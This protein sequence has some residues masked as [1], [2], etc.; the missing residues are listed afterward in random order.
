MSVD[1]NGFENVPREE[2]EVLSAE[3]FNEYVNLTAR[4]YSNSV[5]MYMLIEVIK[6]GKANLD[7]L[8][9]ENGVSTMEEIAKLIEE[10]MGFNIL[11]T[12]TR[13]LIK[14]VPE[15]LISVIGDLDAIIDNIKSYEDYEEVSRSLNLDKNEEIF[16]KKL[17]DIATEIS[18]C[19]LSQIPPEAY[20][21]ANFLRYINFQNTGARLDFEYIKQ[22]RANNY[23]IYIS[24]EN[25]KG[26][27]LISFDDYI[28]KSTE[29]ESSY[30]ITIRINPDNFD[31]SQYQTVI[32]SY[33]IPNKW[34]DDKLGLLL[35]NQ[36]IQDN[37]KWLMNYAFENLERTLYLAES[38]W[39]QLTPETQLEYKDYFKGFLDYV[40]KSGNEYLLSEE[41][42]HT[43]SRI[44]D[45]NSDDLMKIY[46]ND[47]GK[48]E[49]TF[50]YHA[51]PYF[52]NEY[53]EDFY[54]TNQDLPLEKKALVLSQTS[55][56]F[57]NNNFMEL[58]D[59][60]IKENE[61]R[62]SS[63]SN[64]NKL[65]QNYGT[66]E[67]DETNM[68]HFLEVI[69]NA[70]KNSKIE[71]SNA[72]SGIFSHLS[73]KNQIDYYKEFMQIGI[74][75]NASERDIAY[76][77]ERMDPN[78]KEENFN[79]ILEFAQSISPDVA[80]EIRGTGYINMVQA[81]PD[82]RKA[83]F[84]EKNAR[85][86]VI[87][88]RTK[89]QNPEEDYKD[90]LSSEERE[91]FDSSYPT[92]LVKVLLDLD[93]NRDLN[94][95][96]INIIIDNL[97]K[98]GEDVITRLLNSNS[99]MIRANSGQLISAVATLD[100]QSALE[101]IEDTERLFSKDNIPDFVK[102]YKFYENVVERDKHVLQKAIN[103]GAKYPPELQQAG[104]ERA[105][106]RIIFSDLLNIS[107]KSN[108]KSLRKFI[109]LLES[110]NETYV[111]YLNNG[112]DLSLLTEDERHTLKK[113]SETLYTIYDESLVSEH[114][115]KRPSGKIK[116]SKDYMK[117]L[118]EL[119]KRYIGNAFPKDLSNEVLKTVIGRYDELL[120]GKRTLEDFR[121]YMDQINIRS[122]RRHAELAKTK[123]TLESGDLIKGVRNAEDFLQDLFSNG[124]RAGEFL[125]TDTHTDLTPL[126]S[127]HSLILPETIGRNLKDTISRTSSGSY[128]N[129]YLVIKKDPRKIQ[130]TRDD[131]EKPK[132]ETQYQS[133]LGKNA[134][135][136]T[137]KARINNRINGTFEEPRLEAF[138]S[139]VTGNDHYGV[140]TGMSITDVDYIVVSNYD[141]RI[142]YELAMNGTFIPVVNI[143]TNEVVFGVDDYKKIRQQM[144]GLSYYG[145]KK[146][147]I[148]QSAYTSRVEE[149]VAQLFPDGNVEESISEKDAKVKRDA[150]ER[151]ARKA[152]LEKMGLGFESKITGDV[153]PRIY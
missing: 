109:D 6:R 66:H 4:T 24:S 19:D 59:N 53:K 128:G 2:R 56:Q 29:E 121:T 71:Y 64:L 27:E 51:L 77:F 149:K 126:D 8:Y 41:I 115:K 32:Q 81:M 124:I 44:V 84:I 36:E 153:T 37:N 150:I 14:D 72:I 7:T 147:E 10:E 95:S 73:P 148:D 136:E 119:T 74:N 35:V 131:P 43:D 130:F 120:A 104:S 49:D 52:S 139:G 91:K 85:D 108:N 129:F 105:G 100:R 99:D 145:T 57:I 86:I 15:E 117:T 63:F 151:K 140:R 88:L 92:D 16:N 30:P 61:K 122:N 42:K 79:S 65:M 101:V 25:L 83:D 114:D 55:N 34:V 143:D 26:T 28:Y 40:K 89:F 20:A 17:V 102:L 97:P 141:K 60:F 68:R 134:D 67:F 54:Q 12:D 78:I 144:Q 111:K 132:G 112:G 135:R 118:E 80:R 22:N 125:G 113:Y 11:T 87:S 116:N 38:V 69:D 21:K 98:L 142:G 3:K 146:F 82:D 127:D 138:S 48:L 9:E 106:K 90:S 23:N 45:E 123:L 62:V 46:T 1:L 103:N 110:G 33:N 107:L 152:I 137:I 75:H 13:E 70:S 58:F 133:K 76:V 93:K 50:Y 47:D 39:E 5:E 94:N 31:I 96:N 18:K